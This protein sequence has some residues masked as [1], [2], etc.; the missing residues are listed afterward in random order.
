MKDRR[1]LRQDLTHKY[2]GKYT[3][4]HF[5][6]MKDTQNRKKRGPTS[7]P[8]LKDYTKCSFATKMLNQKKETE[9]VQISIQIILNS[10]ALLHFRRWLL[11][12]LVMEGMDDLRDEETDSDISQSYSL[13]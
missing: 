2:R 9:Y 11:V 13:A 8:N 4:T 7:E 5:A 12:P 6:T 10:K 1:L 3:I